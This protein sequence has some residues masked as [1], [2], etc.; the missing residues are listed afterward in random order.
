[1]MKTVKWSSS[2]ELQTTYRYAAEQNSFLQTGV[3]KNIFAVLL[4][5]RITEQRLTGP[6]TGGG[7]QWNKALS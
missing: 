2:S 5:N 4:T 6:L 3:V 7:G 1:M